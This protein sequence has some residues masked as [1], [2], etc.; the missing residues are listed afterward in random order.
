MICA[1]E[2]GEGYVE[3]QAHRSADDR[4]AEASGGGAGSAALPL[5][6][7][8]HHRLGDVGNQRRGDLTTSMLWVS[9]QVEFGLMGRL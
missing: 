9:N 3:E 1:K 8:F 7:F 5:L 4:G 6:D 2:R